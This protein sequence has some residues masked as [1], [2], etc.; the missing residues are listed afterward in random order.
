MA[1]EQSRNHSL[2]TLLLIIK[3]LVVKKKRGVLT[4]MT[5]SNGQ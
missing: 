1:T 3:L 4:C 5:L 2:S